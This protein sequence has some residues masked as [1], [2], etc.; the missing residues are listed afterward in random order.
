MQGLILTFNVINMVQMYTCEKEYEE[1]VVKA[2][3]D[4]S[5]N[6]PI[7]LEGIDL[8]VKVNHLDDKNRIILIMG[9]WEQKYVVAEPRQQKEG[10]P[11]LYIASFAGV[12][13]H[14]YKMSGLEC[15]LWEVYEWDSPDLKPAGGGMIAPKEDGFVLFGKSI[16]Y[17]EADHDKVADILTKIGYETKVKR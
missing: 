5:F 11:S 2:V 13:Y 6:G 16:Y 4:P 14:E 3:A 9:N 1:T 7:S 17:G 15:G 10:Q 12:A 8:E